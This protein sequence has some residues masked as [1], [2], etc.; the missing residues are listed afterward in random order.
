MRPVI[1]KPIFFPGMPIQGKNG[2][3]A[4]IYHSTGPSAGRKPI[5]N[6]M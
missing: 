4:V 3:V 2:N 1:K 6:L 5:M